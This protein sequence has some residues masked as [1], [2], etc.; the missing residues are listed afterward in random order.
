MQT[1]EAPAL[2]SAR[3]MPSLSALNAGDP[4]H[5]LTAFVANDPSPFVAYTLVPS[6]HPP[7]SVPRRVNLTTLLY[8]SLIGVPD[9]IGSGSE[10]WVESKL[11][12]VGSIQPIRLNDPVRPPA[13]TCAA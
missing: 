4:E 8:V 2:K 6:P 11:I 13:P 5:A 1:F 9:A 7:P 10:P 12:V 3:M